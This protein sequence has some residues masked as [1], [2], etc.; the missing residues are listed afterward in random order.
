MLDVSRVWLSANAND[1][2]A[3]GQ[4]YLGK[5]T[6]VLP[7]HAQYKGIHHIPALEFQHV[8]PGG[9]TNFCIHIAGIDNSQGRERKYHFG[10]GKYRLAL[11][12]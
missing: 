2:M 6:T 5:V 12:R 10:S 1:L 9:C 11:A 7:V 4:K 8:H 3:P